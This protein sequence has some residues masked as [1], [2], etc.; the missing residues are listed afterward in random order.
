MN[1]LPPIITAREL[2]DQVVDSLK[3]K[4]EESR[5]EEPCDC[6]Y[7]RLLTD[8]TNPYPLHLVN[9]GDYLNWVSQYAYYYSVGLGMKTAIVCVESKPLTHLLSLIA[10]ATGIPKTDLQTLSV[11]REHFGSLNHGL[12][13]LWVPNPLFCE[14]PQIDLNGLIALIKHLKKHQDVEAVIVDALHLI[15]FDR[16]NPATRAKQRLISSVL[17]S[18]AHVGKLQIVAGFY[19]PEIDFPTLAADSVFHCGSGENETVKA[20]QRRIAIASLAMAT[21]RRMRAVCKSLFR[22]IVPLF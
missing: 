12:E 16:K 22:R 8:A 3:V 17:R 9:G 4:P 14:S 19:D 6:E 7:M 20:D 10:L 5:L 18:T 2:L 15:R 1:L 11:C 21:I 13:Q